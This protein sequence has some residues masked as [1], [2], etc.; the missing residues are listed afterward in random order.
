MTV[1][2]KT[3]E[4]KNGHPRN[5]ANIYIAPKTGAIGC[6]AC[7][8]LVAR[9]YK[10]HNKSVIT[11]AM[12]RRYMDKSFFDGNRERAITRD[13][14]KCVNCGLSREEHLEKYGRDITV[15]HVDGKGRN[16]AAAEQ[17]HSLDNLQTLCLAC[18]GSKDIARR[19]YRTKIELRNAK[20]EF[21]TYYG[22]YFM[23]DA[24]TEGFSTFFDEEHEVLAR[25]KA[26]E[27]QPGW[28]A[29]LRKQTYA[30]DGD[31]HHHHVTTAVEL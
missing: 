26:S 8:K 5:E 11:L 23:N 2:P 9:R 6:K 16:T 27:V 10:S 3:S 14:G 15:D 31:A 7:R 20:C 24:K 29:Y 18:H 25:V 21:K 30:T 12:R 1:S 22:V 19:I 28:W 4:C 13:G 17:N